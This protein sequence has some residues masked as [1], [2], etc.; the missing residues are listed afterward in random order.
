MSWFIRKYK[1]K[2][3]HKSHNLQNGK[4]KQNQKRKKFY[5]KLQGEYYKQWRA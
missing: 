5:F 2:S 1:T 3:G 4:G